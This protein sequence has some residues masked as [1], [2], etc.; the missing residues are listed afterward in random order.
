[1]KAIDTDLLLPCPQQVHLSA[2][3]CDLGAISGWMLAPGALSGP[4]GKQQTSYLAD[5][6]AEVFGR[7][8]TRRAAPDE[9][10][11]LLAIDG[12]GVEGKG[13][14][15]YVLKAGP[16]G[17]SITGA[18]ARAIFWGIQ[19]LGQIRQLSVGAAFRS[20][21]IRDWPTMAI[22]GYSDDMSRKQVSTLRDLEFIIRQMARFKLNMYQPYMED[23]I[24]IDRHPMMGIN[25][26]RLTRDEVGYLVEIG[27]RNFVDILPLFNSCAHCENMLNQKEYHHLRFENNPENLDPRL[28]EVRRLLEGV[29]EQLFE[30]F[31]CEYFHVGLDEARGLG[32]RPDL[33]VKHANWLAKI[34]LAAGRRPIMYHDMFVPYHAHFTK[35]SARWLG[36]LDRRIIL[37]QWMYGDDPEFLPEMTRRGF[38]VIISPCMRGSYC[39]AGPEVWRKNNNFTRYALGYPGI[40]GMLDT[41]WNHDGMHDRHLN[42]RGLGMTGQVTWSGPAGESAMARMRRAF[43]AQFYGLADRRMSDSLDKLVTF[44]EGNCFGGLALKLPV[45][46]AQSCGP[47]RKLQAQAKR[48]AAEL[49]GHRKTI[50]EAMRKAKCNA[51]QLRHVELGLSRIGAGISRVLSAGG[52]LDALRAGS[53]VRIARIAAKEQ[54]AMMQLRETH[55][56][57]WLEVH[58]PEGLEFLDHHYRGAVSALEYLAWRTRWNR[59]RAKEL[60]AGG[61][62]PLDLSSAATACPGEM[63]ALPWGLNVLD[64]IPW[65]VADPGKNGGK[66]VVMMR[67]AR[68]RKLPIKAVIHVGRRARVVHFLHSLHGNDLKNPGRYRLIFADGSRQ[69]IPLRPGK[70]VADWWMPFGHLFGGGGAMRIDTRTT[71]LAFLTGSEYLQG[72]CLYHFRRKVSNPAAAIQ[73]IEVHAGDGDVSLLLAAVTLE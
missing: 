23:I 47:N 69:D 24:Y 55:A 51:G 42:W 67:S 43:D 27:R 2:G 61:L 36:K 15:S 19:T 11:I 35:Y 37:D 71:R 53:A 1:M 64:N 18:S 46:L 13:P 30:Q 28:P 9:R 52:L 59:R 17:V 60:M 16:A 41:T 66:S 63:A 57:I 39:G 34:V 12:R 5:A 20:I 56:R 21:I 48:T 62:T 22:R 31:P 65:L 29:Y 45:E 49:A 38:E 58:K 50:A 10:T 3:A 73:R 33:Y 8:L 7:K 25:R 68:L 6:L 4:A 54:D 14:E 32:E 44:G 40:L 26:G 70:D 72:H